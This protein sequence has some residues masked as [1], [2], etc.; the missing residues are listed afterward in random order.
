M[1]LFSMQH[2]GGLYQVLTF[3]HKYHSD[4][5]AVL[6]TESINK[7]NHIFQGLKDAGFFSDIIFF[8]KQYKEE[9]LVSDNWENR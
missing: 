7:S 4:E 3:L 5:K 8:E 1:V 6:F 2:V 9:H